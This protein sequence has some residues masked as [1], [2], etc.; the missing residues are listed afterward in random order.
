MER[1]VKHLYTYVYVGSRKWNFKVTIGA[2][3]MI[4]LIIG[5]FL[6]TASLTC[7]DINQ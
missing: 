3:L 2:S 7:R 1:V 5:K 4:I 6:L